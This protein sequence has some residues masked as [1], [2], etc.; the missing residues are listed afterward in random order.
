MNMVKVNELKVNYV[1]PKQPPSPVR[2]GSQEGTS[3]RA[4]ISENGTTNTTD[5]VAVP[6]AYAAESYDKPPEVIS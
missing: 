5:S 1:V 3:P 4:S 2:E 6:R